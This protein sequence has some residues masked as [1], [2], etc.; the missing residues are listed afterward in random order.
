MVTGLLRSSIT[1][2]IPIV[3]PMKSTVEY[4]FLLF[5]TSKPAKSSPTITT[6]TMVSWMM[7]RPVRAGHKT[8]DEVCTPKQRLRG[9]PS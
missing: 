4:L 5:G 6:Y 8:A 1:P 9:A 3:S 2:A 7:L